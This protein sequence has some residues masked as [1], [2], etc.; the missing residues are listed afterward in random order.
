MADQAFRAS[1][2]LRENPR[3]LK[4][5]GQL[6]TRS[7][8]LSVNRLFPQGAYQCFDGVKVEACVEGVALGS[9]ADHTAIARSGQQDVQSRTLGAL[10]CENACIS[11]I[12]DRKGTEE[13][14]AVRWQFR[15]L[16]KVHVQKLTYGS[17]IT[18]I[19]GNTG[20]VYPPVA[21]SQRL[22][23]GCPAIATYVLSSRRTFLIG[24]AKKT[25]EF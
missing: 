25:R 20:R 17:V 6:Q 18:L 11:R 7:C 8:V 5:P 9:L 16:V 13:P 19:C 15:H 3:P 23:S 4:L 22:I 24:L 12:S 10:N 1:L 14:A 2:D 21:F